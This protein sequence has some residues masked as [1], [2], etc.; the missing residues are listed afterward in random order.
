MQSKLDGSVIYTNLSRDVLDQDDGIVSDIWTIDGRDVYRGSRDVSYTHANVYWLYS[1][2]LDRVGLAEHSLTDHAD[3]RVLW[4]YDC[5]FAT[6]YQ[7]EGWTDSG[8]I[9]SVL[10]SNA[11]EHFLALGCT[12]AKSITERCLNGPTR[13]VTLDM[14]LSPPTVYS[15]T[16][17]GKKSFSSF[18]H[19]Q[20][21][22]SLLDFPDQRRILFVDDDLIVWDPTEGLPGAAGSSEE[23]TSLAAPAPGEPPA[24]S[25][26]QTPAQ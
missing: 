13:V 3:V 26:L 22:T 9:W 16:C 7:Q 2:D 8:S 19:D 4:F 6:Y 15:C 20:M 24:A 11:T 14:W 10:S 1:E 25:P 23:Q 12:T 18:S 21:T 17:C 5:P